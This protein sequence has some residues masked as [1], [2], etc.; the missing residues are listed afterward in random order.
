MKKT[1]LLL[2]VLA[3]VLSLACVAV[4]YA[5]ESDHGDP[6]NLKDW[7]KWEPKVQVM[8]NGV[9]VQSV[10][11]ACE[12]AY[13]GTSWNFYAGNG[14]KYYNTYFL[15]ADNR[16][17][18]ACHTLQWA[19]KQINH[20]I[21]D[22]AYPTNTMEYQSCIGCHSSTYSGMGLQQPIHTTHLRSA[23]FDSMGGSCESCHYIDSEGNYLR[24]DFVK[25]DVMYG[26]T[27]VS[28][29]ELSYDLEWNQTEV[30]PDEYVFGSKWG[31]A[32]GWGKTEDNQF[33]YTLDYTKQFDN[34]DYLNTYK[35]TIDGLVEKP[36]EY[37][38]Q[39]LIDACGSVKDTYVTH[40]TINGN[41]GSFIYQAEMT[42]IPV[43]KILEYVGADMTMNN[44]ICPLGY[45]NYYYSMTLENV[46]KECG[47][48]VYEYNGHKLTDIEGFPVAYNCHHISAGNM[49]RTVTSLT[50]YS[51]EEA[52]DNWVYGEYYG[53]F[54]DDYS[55]YNVS[56][57]NMGVLTAYN[58]QIFTPGETVHLEGYANAYEEPIT[59][60]EFSFDKGETWFEA[61]TSTADSVRWVYWKLD[62]KDLPEGAYVMW[63]RATSLNDETNEPRVMQEIPKFLINVKN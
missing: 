9:R 62:L 41:G 10:P 58:G 49:T 20:C 31:N 8:E 27:M 12:P 29:D 19:M 57:P 50:V 43:E 56:K 18:T 3:L 47:M 53:D 22:G 15:N 46:I 61:D 26:M 30:T 44:V 14:W 54:M 1:H 33:G 38:L 2:L 35:I 17:C 24:W 37:S 21:Y 42:G 36:G 52:N 45:D 7:D 39:E 48:L 25:Y 63:M 32:Y 60:I 34:D 5:E 40:C 4:S 13:G 11:D 55:G 16:G 59:K 51:W 6:S 23:A 28:A